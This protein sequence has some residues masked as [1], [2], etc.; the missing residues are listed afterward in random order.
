MTWDEWKSFQLRSPALAKRFAKRHPRQIPDPPPARYDTRPARARHAWTPDEDRILRQHWGQTLPGLARRLE[1]SPRAIR[2]RA[3]K[4]GLGPPLEGCGVSVLRLAA[5]SGFS[6]TKIRN[7]AAELGIELRRA[8][9]GRIRDRGRVR[10][11]TFAVAP[12]QAD[13]ILAYMLETPVIGRSRA[14]ATGSRP[15]ACVD[16]GETS[17]PHKARGR[18]SRCYLRRRHERVC[19]EETAVAPTMEAAE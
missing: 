14:W 6:V 17:R 10:A 9:A 8:P 1:R 3:A 18:C 11:R 15:P 5:L 4:L 12:R 7:A 2:D 13:R 16:C 19:V